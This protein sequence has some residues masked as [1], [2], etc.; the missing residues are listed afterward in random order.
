MSSL[1]QL[2][3]QSIL[4][5]H[6]QPRNSGRLTD[7]TH[8]SEGQNPLCGDRLTLSLRIAEERIMAVACDT[9]G[10]AICRA[11]GS[12]LTDAVMGR[13]VEEVT[14]LVDRFLLAVASPEGHEELM[15]AEWGPLAALF[16]VRRFPS[17]RR[18][19]TLSW[20]ALRR[21]LGVS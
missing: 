5:H 4:D 2:Y 20:E 15:D 18:C 12:M 6:R 19:A 10:C 3:Q 16:Q 1:S 21:A 7:S 11:S 13:T 17:R 8:V 9:A 14:V